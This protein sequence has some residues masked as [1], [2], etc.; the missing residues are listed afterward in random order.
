MILKA[1]GEITSGVFMISGFE[2]RG[3]KN[4]INSSNISFHAIIRS[5]LI[6]F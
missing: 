1:K 5:L 2:I 4:K 3:E 6:P